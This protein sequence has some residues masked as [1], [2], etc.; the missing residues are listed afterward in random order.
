MVVGRGLSRWA[1]IPKTDIILLRCVRCRL[2]RSALVGPARPTSVYVTYSAATLYAD[3]HVMRRKVHVPALQWG[4]GE[5][6]ERNVRQSAEG[7]LV[8]PTVVVFSYA[9]A[10]S[11]AGGGACEG[12]VNQ[13]LSPIM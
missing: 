10:F 2:L 12:A 6:V 7:A 5:R 4:W 1:P 11:S 3:R 9:S 8:E 13:P